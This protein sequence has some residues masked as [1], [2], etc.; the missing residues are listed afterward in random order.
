MN[1]ILFIH[2]SIDG[3]MGCLHL[4]AIVTN[5]AMNMGMQISL[6]VPALNSFAYIPRSGTAV[7]RGIFNIKDFIWV[8]GA[9]GLRWGP[10]EN[11]AHQQ[12]RRRPKT[13]Q[14]PHCSP[15]PTRMSWLGT[16]HLLRGEVGLREPRTTTQVQKV[17]LPGY[18]TVYQ[19]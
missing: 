9:G 17:S 13:P 1:P 12:S 10:G 15:L 3:Y 5:A 2:S 16:P 4:L 14:V 11:A 8:R 19:A 7:S 18:L 6:G